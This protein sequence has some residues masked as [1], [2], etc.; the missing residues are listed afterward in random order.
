MVSDL[1]VLSSQDIGRR[2]RISLHEA[3][4]IVNIVLDELQTPLLLSLDR[5]DLPQDETITTGDS[6][7]DKI[8]GG[9]VRTRKLWEI[10]GERCSILPIPCTGLCDLSCIV[11]RGRHN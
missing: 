4:E 1:L 9:G 2:C 10:T 3:Q 6:I 5:R 7:L 11:Q 8:L